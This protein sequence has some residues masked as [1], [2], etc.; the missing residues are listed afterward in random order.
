MAE[1]EV[2]VQESLFLDEQS[3]KCVSETENCSLV[4]GDQSG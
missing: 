1:I 4:N 2:G 3:A